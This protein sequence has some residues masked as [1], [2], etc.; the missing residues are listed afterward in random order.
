MDKIKEAAKKLSVSNSGP[1]VSLSLGDLT[2][3][4]QPTAGFM[5]A[6]ELGQIRRR[7]IRISTGSKQLDAALNGSVELHPVLGNH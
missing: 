5:T 7:C 2:N 4:A 3:A 6:A 1:T